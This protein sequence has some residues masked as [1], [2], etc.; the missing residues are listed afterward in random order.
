MGMACPPG[1]VVFSFPPL[2]SSSLESD[3]TKFRHHRDGNPA[4]MRCH[5]AARCLKAAFDHA[6]ALEKV[7]VTP[8]RAAPRKA[9][10]SLCKCMTSL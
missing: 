2:R 7:Q 5:E 3:F 1:P 4:K 9:V 6:E 8:A 10:H